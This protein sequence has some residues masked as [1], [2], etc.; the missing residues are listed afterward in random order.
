MDSKDMDKSIVCGFFGPPCRWPFDMFVNDDINMAN[1]VYSE[2][3]SSVCQW[4]SVWL[5]AHI[6]GQVLNIGDGTT[7]LLV[8]DGSTLLCSELVSFCL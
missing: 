2:F 7:V 4:E 3:V 8:C 1:N 5:T 6:L